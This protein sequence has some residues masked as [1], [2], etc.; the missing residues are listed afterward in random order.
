MNKRIGIIGLGWLG[1]PLGQ[2]LKELGYLVKGTTTDL[3]KKAQLIKKGLDAFILR[4]TEKGITGDTDKFFKDL[5]I[6]VLNIPPKIKEDNGAAYP[7]MIQHI[8]HHATA[9]GIPKLLF[10][11]STSVYG[12]FQGEVDESTLPLPDT[13]SGKSILQA[14]TTLLSIQSLK[15]TLIRFGG[16]IGA[17]RHPIY[18]LSG[19]KNLKN[20]EEYVNL[21]HQE[22]CIGMIHFIIKND[23]WG[24]VFNGVYPH[25]PKKADYYPKI[26]GQLGISPPAYDTNEEVKNLKI[27]R[28]LN[29]MKKNGRFYTSIE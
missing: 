12:S 4:V 27:V 13:K 3:D 6:L 28:S 22:D 8:A 20:G 11:S 25:H 17:E 18:A 14:E 15:T 2:R 7:K 5:E 26:A 24:E 19:R 23:L 21:I 9:L 10:V 16:L 1:D 29:Y